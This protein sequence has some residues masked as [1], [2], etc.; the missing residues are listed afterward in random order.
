MKRVSSARV[1]VSI[2]FV[3]AP[4]TVILEKYKNVVRAKIYHNTSNNIQRSNEWPCTYINRP[5]VVNGIFDQYFYSANTYCFDALIARGSPDARESC[6]EF[7][8]P[9]ITTLRQR[10]RYLRAY[11]IRDAWL[12]ICLPDK[13]ARTLVVTKI[14]DARKINSVKLG[15]VQFRTIRLDDDQLI[16]LRSM[17]ERSLSIVYFDFDRGQASQNLRNEPRLLVSPFRTPTRKVTQIKKYKF[18]GYVSEKYAWRTT[19][20]TKNVTSLTRKLS[21]EGQ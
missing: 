12:I 14:F 21:T 11:I 10:H 6:A 4:P 7:I 3:L 19:T 13:R 15:F 9:I 2:Y 16:S 18:W 1:S 17:P 20:C 5:C 8:P